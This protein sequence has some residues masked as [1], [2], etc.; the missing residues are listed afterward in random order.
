M[1]CG[2]PVVSTNVGGLADLP[3]VQADPNS[4]DLCEKMIMVL[5]DYENINIINY[6]RLIKI[7]I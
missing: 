4:D 7:L 2:C 3:T 5:K 6:T 1:A